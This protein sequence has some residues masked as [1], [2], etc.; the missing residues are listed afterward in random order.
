MWHIISFS[1]FLIWSLFIIKKI[2]KDS[3]SVIRFTLG[4]RNS[5][6]LLISCSFVSYCTAQFYYQS[7]R[8]IV[9]PVLL[10]DGRIQNLFRGQLNRRKWCFK[11]LRVFPLH[12]LYILRWEYFFFNVYHIKLSVSVI[13]ASLLQHVH[14]RDCFY[15]TF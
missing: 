2:Y 6:S 3:Y 13:F 8:V 7:E 5:E 10:L 12:S 14:K 15:C 1:I 9:S 4:M 11:M